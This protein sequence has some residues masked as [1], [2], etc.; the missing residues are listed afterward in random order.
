MKYIASA[1]NISVIMNPSQFTI[2]TTFTS[3]TIAIVDDI[4]DSIVYLFILR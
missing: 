1:E 3:P 2:S 4:I